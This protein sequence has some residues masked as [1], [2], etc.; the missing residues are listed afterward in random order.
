[1]YY[2]ELFKGLNCLNNEV[3]DLVFFLVLIKVYEV[4]VNYLEKI[5]VCIILKFSFL[6]IRFVL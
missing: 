4:F 1:M 5:M 6:V 3:F 2:C